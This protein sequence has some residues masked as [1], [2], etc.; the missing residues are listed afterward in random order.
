MKTYCALYASSNAMSRQ[1]GV[2]LI[3]A[4]IVL[5]SMTLAAI[6]M[7]RSIDTANSIAGNIAFKQA[8][9]QSSDLGIQAATAWLNA[10]SGGSTLQSNDALNGYFSSSPA[11]EP[12][13][14]DMANWTNAA[15]LSGGNADA[16]G[17][18]VRYVVHR[19][20]TQPA[21]AYNGNNAGVANQCALSI[22]V[23]GGG[24]GGSMAVGSTQFPGAPQLY[25]R[26]TTRVDGPRNT[27][28]IVQVTMQI[29]V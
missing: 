17:N 14:A 25:Y 20:C 6:G 28:S 29:Q 21:T 19:M 26:I 8:S 3:I 10:N 18:V 24:A 23:S 13:W 27:V 5:V 12:N 9:V 7:S 16:A 11:T 2:V 1:R 15:V 22:P 4:L